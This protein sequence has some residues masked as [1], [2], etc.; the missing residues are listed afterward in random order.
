MVFDR[1]EELKLEGYCDADWGNGED[2]K[3]ISGWVF[4]LAGGAVD[5][6]ARKQASTVLSSIEAEYMA[7]SEAV[8]SSIWIRN[9]LQDKSDCR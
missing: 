8:K 3:S 7:L 6:G 9:L 2:R 5:W 4:K 1:K